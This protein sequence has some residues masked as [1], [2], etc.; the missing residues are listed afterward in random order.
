MSS[1]QMAGSSSSSSSQPADAQR[2]R[3]NESK[4]VHITETPMTR[5]NWYKHVNWL[6]V[7][8]IV[9]FPLYGIIGAFWVP[10]HLKTAVW[11]VAYYFCTGLGITAGMYSLHG[12]HEKKHPLTMND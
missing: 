7:A 6:N 11:A 8:F 12:Q 5:Q 9:L 4:K 1:P 10:L 3:P 2:P